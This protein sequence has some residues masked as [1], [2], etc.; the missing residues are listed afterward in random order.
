[1][2]HHDFGHPFPFLKGRIVD[3]L[4]GFNDAGINPRVK[5]FPHVR[6]RGD[7]KNQ[8]AQRFFRGRMTLDGGPCPGMRSGHRGHIKGRGEVINDRVQNFLHAAV[9][10][11]GSH[12][13]REKGI[14]YNAP[15]DG[16]DDLFRRDILLRQ[17]LFHNN[18]VACGQPFQK[19][20]ADLLCFFLQRGRDVLL[21]QFQAFLI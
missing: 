15:P 13:G 1:M 19:S 3:R 11:S 20:P 12:Q 7:F 17:Q 8:G 14:L 4:P 10:Q 9:S 21:F 2:H 5:Q 16:R 18:I 6:V